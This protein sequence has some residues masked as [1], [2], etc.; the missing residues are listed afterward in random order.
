MTVTSQSALTNEERAALYKRLGTKTVDGVRGLWRGCRQRMYSE[1][2]FLRRLPRWAA[3]L[4]FTFYETEDEVVIAALKRGDVAFFIAFQLR[5][6][7][8][9]CEAV[10][11]G[12]TIA[13]RQPIIQTRAVLDGLRR[14]AETRLGALGGTFPPNPPEPAA[15]LDPAKS[16]G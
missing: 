4:A 10:R 9:D 1:Q 12:L 7:Q 2:Q 3:P 13:E 8:I 5:V 6:D 14:V 16:P 15:P 11:A